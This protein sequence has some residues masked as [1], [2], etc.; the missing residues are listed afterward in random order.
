MWIALDPSYFAHAW[1][2]NFS[3]FFNFAFNFLNHFKKT[4]NFPSSF[5]SQRSRP[6][7]ADAIE[8]EV[9]H[10]KISKFLAHTEAFNPMRKP[11]EFD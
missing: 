11:R 1:S 7:K 3:G 4:W 10:K 8:F 6:K 5:F 9:F 2:K